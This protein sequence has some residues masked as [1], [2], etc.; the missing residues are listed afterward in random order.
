MIQLTENIFWDENLEY[1]SQANECKDYIQNVIGN[2]ARLVETEDIPM[3]Y[4]KRKT[5]AYFDT[6]LGAVIC[7]E[8]KYKNDT[9][10]AG[11][12]E[13]KSIKITVSNG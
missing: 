4:N 10:D 2:K 5:K 1:E 13:V 6:D 12:E 9:K 11:W 8:I 7:E 3:S